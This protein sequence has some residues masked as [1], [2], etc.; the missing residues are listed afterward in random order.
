LKGKK[1]I[2]TTTNR[3][4]GTMGPMSIV[5]WEQKGEDEKAPKEDGEG[6]GEEGEGEKAEAKEGEETSGG[7]EGG[8]RKRKRK[9]R[10]REDPGSENYLGP[11]RPPPE[12]EVYKVPEPVPTRLCFL[13]PTP[14]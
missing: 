4:W 5:G 14:S 13:A 3:R 6:E 2:L 9:D 12:L 10:E 1:G 8:K 7:S 11:W